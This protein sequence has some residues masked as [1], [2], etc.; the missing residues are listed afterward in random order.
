MCI[1]DLKILNVLLVLKKMIFVIKYLKYDKI[2]FNINYQL[3]VTSPYV[4]FFPIFPSSHRIS[5][6]STIKA[7]NYIFDSLPSPLIS[8]YFQI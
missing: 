4:N 8:I 1:L 2:K 3:K 6:I 7:S 5:T